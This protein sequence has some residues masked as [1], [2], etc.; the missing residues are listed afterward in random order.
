MTNGCGDGQTGEDK[1]TDRQTLTD[2]K[3]HKMKE[4]HRGFSEGRSA[5]GSMAGLQKDVETDR[6][7]VTDNKLYEMK[8]AHR[9]FSRREECNGLNGWTSERCGERQTDRQTDSDRQQTL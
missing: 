8:E 6:Q 2:K 7:T 4:T 9:G 3:L 1:W 5:M